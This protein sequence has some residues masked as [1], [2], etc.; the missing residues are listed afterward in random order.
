M[1]SVA[2]RIFCHIALLWF[3]MTGPSFAQES[4]AV[5]PPIDANAAADTTRDFESLDKEIHSL[6][7]QADY[8]KLRFDFDSA[9]DAKQQVLELKR[10]RFPAGDWRI[11]DAEREVRD[12]QTEA[13][14]A[15]VD[16]DGI[17]E[18]WRMNAQCKESLLSGQFV[19]LQ[20]TAEA[21]TAKADQLFARKHT[22]SITARGFLSQ[23][24]LFAGAYDKASPVLTEFL[25]LCDELVGEDHPE[26]VAAITALGSLDLRLGRLE[27]AE[28]R[29]TNALQYIDGW[30]KNPPFGTLNLAGARL[31][32]NELTSLYCQQGDLKQAADHLAA[33]A[34]FEKQFG[35]DDLA[36][37]SFVVA[38]QSDVELWRG[39]YAA[40]YRFFVDSLRMS[41]ESGSQSAIANAL[42]RGIE[43]W[44]C[45]DHTTAARQLIRS[46]DQVVPD[47][48]PHADA[49]IFAYSLCAAGRHWLTNEEYEKAI[50]CYR[51]GFWL[52]RPH[53]FVVAGL[54]FDGARE[55]GLAFCENGQFDKAE[56]ILL[57]AQS[58][59]TGMTPLRQSSYELNSHVLAKLRLRQGRKAEAVEFAER[60]LTNLVAFLGH[61]NLLLISHLK[62]RLEIL[63]DC[64][65]NDEAA[66]VEKHLQELRTKAKEVR[67][68]L[69]AI[70]R[71][72]N[73][74]SEK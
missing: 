60:G 7:G 5:T 27:S 8:A 48:A 32:Y 68:E 11:D 34:E 58:K 42:R 24:Y 19:R 16:R 55:S 1:R 9:I 15:A 50:A 57:V 12:L 2:S 14:V 69:K 45:V 74:T 22:S 63:K 31:V 23:S 65:L 37:L 18:L 64:G 62:L 49:A 41:R 52:A 13:A 71:Q 67:D 4:P 36:E 33:F 40:A 44:D 17:L 72:V 21:M 25:A 38:R 29:F 46:L 30:K 35:G 10:K 56:K 66:G 73:A 28:Q 43:V 3:A 6:A 59:A 47:Q 20:A 53:Q 54:M 51:R 39:D 26:R 61:D 70:E